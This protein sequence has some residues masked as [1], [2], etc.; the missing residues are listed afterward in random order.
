MALSIEQLN[1]VTHLRINEESLIWNI[2]LRQLLMA[3]WRDFISDLLTGHA[4]KNGNTF[5]YLTNPCLLKKN[6][7]RRAT[8]HLFD[9]YSS[10]RTSAHWTTIHNWAPIGD[11]TKGC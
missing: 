8:L 1:N 7:P 5:A 6:G 3:N 10:S 2:L 9:N 11:R 4:S